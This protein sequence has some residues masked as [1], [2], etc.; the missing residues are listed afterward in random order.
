MNQPTSSTLNF[1]MGDDRATGVT[2]ALGDGGTL[3][4]TYFSGNISL[5]AQVV[6][7][8]T[9]YFVGNSSGARYVPLTPARILDSRY[10][11][12]LSGPFPSQAART[13]QVTG[14]G[15]VPSSA[16]AVTGTL[17]VTQQTGLG[18][19]YMGLAPMNQPTSST[20]N[21]PIADDR[22]NGATV[23]LGDG[24][25]LSVTYYST[26]LSLSAQ[27]IFDVTGY[28]VGNPSGG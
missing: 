17:T 14:Q 16:T 26:N 13:F 11:T 12:G 23:A 2:V 3:S 27:A 19:L 5:S 22:A 6:F 25:T 1:P 20:L 10:G 4:V 8:V 7:D 24:G 21:F 28:F 9:G 15:G 18:Y